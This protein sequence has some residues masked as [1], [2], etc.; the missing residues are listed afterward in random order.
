MRADTKRQ[1][2]GPSF[3]E[4]VKRPGVS[5]GPVPK[6]VISNFEKTKN[7]KNKNLYNKRMKIDSRF[8]EDEEKEK[9]EEKQEKEEK[10]DKDS[11]SEEERNPK[12]RLKKKKVDMEANEKVD[13]APEVD[14]VVDAMDVDED[15][16]A[17]S[18]V[19]KALRK[20][21]N[22][23]EENE[24][25]D[26]KE[27]N[28]EEL[29]RLR[30]RRE[31]RKRKKKERRL[32]R[33]SQSLFEG[34]ESDVATPKKTSSNQNHNLS[35]G[36]E[37]E[38]PESAQKANGS[39]KLRIPIVEALSRPT[40]NPNSSL[41]LTPNPKP[42]LK[43]NFDL[44]K[45]LVDPSNNMKS[46]QP[47]PKAKGFV[48]DGSRRPD[49]PTPTSMAN[50]PTPMKSPSLPT[51]QK[52]L[53]PKPSDPST[54]SHQSRPNV[55]GPV[56][57]A[58]PIPKVEDLEREFVPRNP[59]LRKKRESLME[60]R[61]ALPIFECKAQLVEELRKNRSLVIVGETGMFFLSL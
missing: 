46:L 2:I 22:G 21:K 7:W 34:N 49:S 17:P 57:P 58:T 14:E 53:N 19:R 33:L 45:P 6:S 51:P 48:N 52:L 10:I 59:E 1:R 44:P 13:E 3:D 30:K 20:E 42:S 11:E 27:V 4:F 56:T 36:D 5:V 28:K 9:E 31:E 55:S 50:N 29:E 61:K 40:P 23:K 60:F 41:N 32:S 8:E 25:G 15:A 26:E 35:A 54:P 16:E 39:A 18:M 38:A 47:K 37:Q 12:E 24:R 43:F